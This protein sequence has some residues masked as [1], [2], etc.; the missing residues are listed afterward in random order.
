MIV[1]KEYFFSVMFIDDMWNFIV[2]IY[3][4]IV[5]LLGIKM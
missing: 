2:I 3:K 5:N 4:G 1:E